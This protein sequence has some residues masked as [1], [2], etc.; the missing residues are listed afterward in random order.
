MAAFM[1]LKQLFCAFLQF[2][3]PDMTFISKYV[4]CSDTVIENTEI[5]E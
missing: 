1:F 3:A 2:L 5:V 4:F